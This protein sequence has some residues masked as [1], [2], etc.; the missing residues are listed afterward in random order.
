[1]DLGEIKDE[2]RNCGLTQTKLSKMSGVSN[3]YI[4]KFLSDV[5]ANITLDTFQ[6]ILDAAGVELS[7]KKQSARRVSRKVNLENLAIAQNILILEKE[8]N[9]R[10]DA[11][12]TIV[13]SG[14]SKNI[15]IKE[16]TDKNKIRKIRDELREYCNE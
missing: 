9:R 15:E 10:L 12:K 14:I 1:M 7:V 2:I 11:M 4:S 16:C 6:R 8:F 5:G 13:S 3:A